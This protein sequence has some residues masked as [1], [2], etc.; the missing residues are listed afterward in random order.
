MSLTSKICSYRCNKILSW[1]LFNLPWSKNSRLSSLI[2]CFPS[3]H[4]CSWTLLIFFSLH[5][6]KFLL[7]TRTPAIQVLTIPV[8][9]SL[10]RLW[11]PPAALAAGD[12][13]PWSVPPT[14]THRHKQKDTQTCHKSTY[15][16]YTQNKTSGHNGA[17]GLFGQLSLYPPLSSLKTNTAVEAALLWILT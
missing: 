15:V 8:G 3:T 14:H 13:M 9:E 17:R 5:F 16:V 11:E 2:K 4:W 7:T 12:L 6:A 1:I 10:W